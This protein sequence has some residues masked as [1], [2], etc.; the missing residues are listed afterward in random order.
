MCNAHVQP[1]MLMCRKHWFMV[2][3]PLRDRVWATYNPGQCDGD[4]P[5]TKEWHEAA[6]AAIDAVWKREMARATGGER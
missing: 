6:D 1:E 4:A 5:V 2:P 3:K